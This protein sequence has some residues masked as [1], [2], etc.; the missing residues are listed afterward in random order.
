MVSTMPVS[1]EFQDYVLEQLADIGTIMPKKM[2]GGVGLYQRKIFFGILFNNNLYL[3][4]DDSNRQDY[5]KEGMPPFQPFA[6]RPMTMQYYEVPAEVLEDKA[7]L[8]IWAQTAI[9]V[10]TQTSS[11]TAR[12]QK[13]KGKVG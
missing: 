4:V 11:G 8:G 5:E 2:F 6:G 9:N 10:A 3:K 7:Q 12:K 1:A 13:R